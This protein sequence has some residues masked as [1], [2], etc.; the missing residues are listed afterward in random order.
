MIEV[1]DFQKEVVDSDKPVVADF[2]AP[3][4]GPCRMLAPVFEA[5]SK[6]IKGAKFV[7]VNVDEHQNIASQMG[8]R[9]IPAVMV[10]HKGQPV[11]GLIVGVKPQKELEAEIKKQLEKIK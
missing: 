5:V 6:S 11:G 9:G 7:K 8:I 2:W 1:K 10:L 4:C 3:W